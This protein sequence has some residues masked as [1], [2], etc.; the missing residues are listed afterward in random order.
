VIAVTVVVG[1]GIVR[2]VVAVVGLVMRGVVRWLMV[3]VMGLV[4]LGGLV[5]RVRLVRVGILADSKVR[6]VV[7]FFKERHSVRRASKEIGKP[8]SLGAVMKVS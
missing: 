3:R 8:A 4:G 5:R 1:V 7:F 2:V 6:T